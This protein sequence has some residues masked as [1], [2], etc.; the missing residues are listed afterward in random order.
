MRS[1]DCWKRYCEKE[2]ASACFFCAPQSYIGEYWAITPNEFPY[3]A[4]A[5][6]H[7]LLHPIRHVAHW[8]ELYAYE[9]Q[10]FLEVVEKLSRGGYDAIT[11]NFPSSQTVPDHLHVHLIC[12]KLAE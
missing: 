10:D 6:Q 2:Q 8:S 9:V 7:V 12:Y 5:A 3:D 4:I 11:W 1:E